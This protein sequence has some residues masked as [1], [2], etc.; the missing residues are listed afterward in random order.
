VLAASATQIG[1]GQPLALVAVITSAGGGA[2]SGTVTFVSGSTTLGT[3]TVGANNSASLTLGNLV[4]GIYSITAQYGGDA[5]DAPSTSNAVSV[6]VG[7]TADYT[8]KLSPA[9]LSIPTTEY[10]VTTITLTSESGFAD[11]IALGCSSLPFSVTCTF[12]SSDVKLAANGSSTVQ[13]TIDTNSPLVGGGQ[14]KNESPSPHSGL[15]AA[16]VLPGAAFFGFAFRR[17]RKGHA[18]F[19]VLAIAAMLAGA[20]FLMNGCGGLS[21]SSAKAGTYTIQVTATGVQSGVS[22]TSNLS[23]QV[24]Q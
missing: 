22:H 3:G 7:P 16:C 4:A 12:S 21:L 14:A 8:I 24:T 19:R 9:S 20:T 18:M 23:V 17:F 2:V 15:L 13:L 5:N 1:S 10:G 11:T 6:T